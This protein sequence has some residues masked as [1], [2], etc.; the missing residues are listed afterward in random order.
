MLNLLEFY[1][2]KHKKLFVMQIVIM[3]YVIFVLMSTRQN[4]FMDVST[5]LVFTHYVYYFINDRIESIDG[6]IFKIY[7]RI[8]GKSEDEKEK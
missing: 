5:A 7:D 1:E 6:F 3:M 4:F 2:K 8:A